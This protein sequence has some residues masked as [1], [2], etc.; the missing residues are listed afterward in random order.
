MDSQL[1]ELGRFA[2]PAT[3]ILSSLAGGAKHGYGLTKDIEHFAEVKLGPGTL[4]G[5]LGRLETSSLIEPL[6]SEGRRRPYRI[7]A[8][9]VQAL[10][11]HLA[12]QKQVVEVGLQRL[13]IL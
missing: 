6:P 5:A 7:T 4:Y 13:A 12:A 8:A 9:G 1:S 3:L 10:S 11:S 2:G